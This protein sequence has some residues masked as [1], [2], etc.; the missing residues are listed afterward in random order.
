[1]LPLPGD[2]EESKI[3]ASFKKGVLTIDLPKSAEA[4]QKVKHITIK[5]A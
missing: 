1:V 4:Q 5:A 2:V 3:Q